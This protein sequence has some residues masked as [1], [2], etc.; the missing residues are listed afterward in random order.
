MGGSTEGKQFIIHTLIVYPLVDV[1][2]YF[3]K[4]NMC[5]ITRHNATM[6]TVYVVILYDLYIGLILCAI[7]FYFIDNDALYHMNFYASAD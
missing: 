2:L 6:V 3:M 4:L 1:L 5:L 7:I